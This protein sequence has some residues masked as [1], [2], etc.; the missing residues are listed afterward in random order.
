MMS[1]GRAM[2][3]APFDKVYQ[4]VINSLYDCKFK[5]KKEDRESGTILA[6]AGISSWTWGERLE[7]LVLEKIEGVEVVMHSIPKLASLLYKR[8][9]KMNIEKFFSSLDKRVKNRVY[10]KEFEAY[11]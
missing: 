2:Y 8:K 9:S 3:K 7:I 6:S 1:V 5:V 10:I 4:E 11:P